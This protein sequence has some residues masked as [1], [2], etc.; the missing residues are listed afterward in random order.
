M[1]DWWTAGTVILLT[2]FIYVAFFWK[3]NWVR[4]SIGEVFYVF[5]FNPS[6]WNKQEEYS[7]VRK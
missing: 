5:I 2:L 3:I 6:V 4:V 1:S 7:I